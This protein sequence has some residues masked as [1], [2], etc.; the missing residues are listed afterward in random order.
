MAR[1]FVALDCES[2]KETFLRL[3][4][5]LPE[6]SSLAKSFHVTLKFFREISE[7]GSLV[8]GLKAIQARQIQATLSECGVFPSV[9]HPR[10]AWIGLK[11]EA[12][13][14]ELAN[15]I[16]RATP[17]IRL[18]HGFVPHIT[19]ARFH[20]PL[21]AQSFITRAIPQQNILWKNFILYET[22][23]AKEGV[24]HIPREIFSMQ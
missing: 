8:K 15:Q 9:S 10:V 2:N 19:M 11:P 6:G 5:C 7:I 21:N 13:L 4:E 23:F 16:H 22:I 17:Q 3:Q 18:D 20:Q 1:L 12:P 24:R 14:L